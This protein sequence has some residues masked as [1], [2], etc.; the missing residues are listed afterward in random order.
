MKKSISFSL[1]A[2]LAIFCL[3]SSCKKDKDDNNGD[4]VTWNIN[5]DVDLGGA[6]AVVATAKITTTGSS[7][8]ADITT[9]EIGGAA[10]VHNFTIT[11]NANGDVLSVT[12]AQFTLTMGNGTETVTINSATITING[13]N[14]TGNGTITVIPAGSTTPQNGTFTLTGVRT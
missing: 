3:M 10:E 1:L 12:N 7:F 5:V 4:A 8:S 6:F 2:L 14:M 9:S 13:N 11:G